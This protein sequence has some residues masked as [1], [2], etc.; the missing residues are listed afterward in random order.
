MAKEEKG[1]CYCGEKDIEADTPN[2]VCARCRG[3]FHLECLKSGSPSS[4][5]GDV[6]F[7]FTC[8][9]CGER[10]EEVVERMKM[11][12]TQVVL[13]AL[14][15]LQLS[16]KVGK[17]GYYRWKEHICAFIDKYW[18]VLFGNHRKKTNLWHGTVAGTLS[19]GCPHHF[20]SGAKEL[21]ESGWWRLAEMKPPNHKLMTS[22]NKAGRRRVSHPLPPQDHGTTIKVEGLR[23]RRGKTSIEAAMEL[24]AKRETL[25][26]AKE[27]RKAKQSPL[28]SQTSHLIHVDIKQELGE[29]SG[30]FIPLENTLSMPTP[31]GSAAGQ[32]FQPVFNQVI[33]QEPI[34]PSFLS[35]QRSSSSQGQNSFT[36]SPG[37]SQISNLSLTQSTSLSNISS[38]G[39]VSGSFK[40]VDE[41]SQFSHSSSKNDMWLTEHDLKADSSLPNLLMTDD[42]DNVDSDSDL[43]IDP[44][45]ITPPPGSPSNQPQPDSPTLQDILMSISS[46]DDI[47]MDMDTC[48]NFGNQSEN[49][50]SFQGYKEDISSSSHSNKGVESEE[51]RGV[52]QQEVVIGTST[53]ILSSQ[54]DNT[55]TKV[56]KNEDDQSVVDSESEKES[57]S[58]SS[59]CEG[60][61]SGMAVQ[62]ES[63]PKRK[64]KKAKEADEAKEEETPPPPKVVLMSL[65]EERQLLKKMNNVTDAGELAP[66]LNRLRRKLIVRQ[67]KRERGVPIFDIDV[68]MNRLARKCWGGDWEEHKDLNHHALPSHR[69][70]PGDVRILDRFQTTVHAH[71]AWQQHQ[72]S[73]LNRLVG[74]EDDQLQCITSPY[75]ARILKPFIRRDYETRP[76]KM[77]LLEEIKAYPHRHDKT[78]KPGPP[79]SIDYCYVRPQHIPSVNILCREFFWPGIDLSECLQYPDFSCVVLF[80]KIVIGFAFMV[81]DVKYNEAYIS[82][83]FTHPE[84]RRAGI[85]KFMIYHLIQTCLGKDVN[86]H[87]SATN[88]AMLLYQHYGFKPEEFILDF[89]DK[90]YPEDSRECK[91]AF[92]LRL[93]R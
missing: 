43:E 33:K 22:S 88:S 79:P 44:G 66:A 29:V 20:V 18:L 51:S 38:S 48:T 40:D 9:K 60:S 52:S 57:D 87:V 72:P 19:S 55:Y 78:W 25:L 36:F 5:V 2:L 56:V 39:S 37:S 86:L 92:Y 12:W 1:V 93:R 27:I 4:L 49:Y 14:Y 16:G 85:A 8:S 42:M 13:L 69:L 77:R 76:L 11:Q 7:D 17:F 26:E 41:D 90:Y 89:Y 50:F 82:F 30:K 45:T 3:N 31:S 28:Q 81:P 67:L 47:S 64:R 21:G 46:R 6:F 15:N 58:E 74:T 62:S 70:Q 53:E 84:W 10:H 23:N 61:D 71:Q 59:S 34:D 91:H 54:T 75:T 73:F 24:K 63:R 68:E 32:S 83:L 35:T 80:R 65:Y